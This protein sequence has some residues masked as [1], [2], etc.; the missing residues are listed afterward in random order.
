M[1]QNIIVPLFLGLT[2]GSFFNVCIIR[3]P[4]GKS[5]MWPPSSCTSCGKRIAFWYNIPV[6]SYL[7]LR[8]KCRICSQKISPI[9]PLI[10]ILTALVLVLVWQVTPFYPNEPWY[11]NIV[12]FFRLLSIV[13][14]IPVSVIDLQHYII[15]DR[16]TLPFLGVSFALSFIPG[17]LSPAQ[18]LLGMVAGGGSLLFMGV[19]GTYVFKKGDAMG[20]GDIKLMAYLGALWGASVAL[21]GIVFAAFFGAAVG[22]ALMAAK[23]LN[24]EN[25]IPFGPFLAAGLVI[26]AF[27]GETLLDSYL[28]FLGSLPG[29]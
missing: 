14:L 7:I 25:K 12:P 1:P 8:G 18:S 27:F 16:F 24:Q 21:T 15:P 17:G 28:N 3:I 10:E 13:L 29:L 9:Y 26:A 23:K 5:I 20:G 19:L 11:V 22:I 2:L 6:I 4:Q